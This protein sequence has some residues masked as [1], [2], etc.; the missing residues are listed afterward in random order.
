MPEETYA[1]STAILGL[2]PFMVGIL[3][4]ITLIFLFFKSVWPKMSE[5]SKQN[6]YILAGMVFSV[7]GLA[8]LIIREN[9]LLWA[10]DHVTRDE[11]RTAS[12]IIPLIGSS[13]LVFGIF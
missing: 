11:L 10:G 6:I 13:F 4:V 1:S 2:I 12:V 9:I 8:L 5:K 3:L 7:V